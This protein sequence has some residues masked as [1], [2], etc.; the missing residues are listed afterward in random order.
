MHKGVF[1]GSEARNQPKRILILGESHY[2]IQEST[3]AV[4]E[5]YFREP[6]DISYRFFDKIVGTFGYA[7]VDREQFWAKVYFGNY[8]DVSCGVG[9]RQT[10]AAIKDNRVN[11]N[12]DLIAFIVKEKIDY[13]FCFSRLVYNHLPKLC[14]ENGDDES[15]ILEDRTHYLMKCVY[16]PGQRDDMKQWIDKPLEVYG[17]KHPSRGYSP[18]KYRNAIVDVLHK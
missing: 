11:Y 10:R 4:M 14:R 6:E 15:C 1:I 5:R 17:L 18:Q 13:A 16:Y 7:K 2:G 12:E 3:T 9:N 8:I